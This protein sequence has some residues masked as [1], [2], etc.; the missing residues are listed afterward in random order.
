VIS[1]LAGIQAAV[2]ASSRMVVH[3]I[4]CDGTPHV[5]SLRNS[6]QI[7]RSV[8]VTKGCCTGPIRHLISTS[9]SENV[10]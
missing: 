2:A 10:W 1:H 8:E 6:C 7:K 5:V 3:F 4:E 9:S